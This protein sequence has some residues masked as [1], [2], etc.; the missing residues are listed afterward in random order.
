ME[1]G[2]QDYNEDKSSESDN[3]TFTLEKTDKC[4][5]HQ[6]SSVQSSAYGMPGPS[7][8]HFTDQH[9]V[10]Y[11][12]KGERRKLQIC[13]NNKPFFLFFFYIIT[14]QKQPSFVGVVHDNSHVYSTIL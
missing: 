8:L 9:M 4:N 12:D 7:P 5:K 1:R 6:D 14:A 10:M 3:T 2:A 11:D 13:F